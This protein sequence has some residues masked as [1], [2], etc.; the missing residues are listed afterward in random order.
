MENLKN[1]SRLARTLTKSVEQS[2]L[3]VGIMDLGCG[4]GPDNIFLELHNSGISVYYNGYDFND[5][6]VKRLLKNYPPNFN[7]H[8]KK[9]VT[10]RRVEMDENWFEEFSAG[11]ASTETDFSSY[12]EKQMIDNN[13]WGS[14]LVEKSKDEIYIHQI[15]EATRTSINLLKIDLDGPDFAYLQDYCSH[16]TQLPQFVS[17]EINYQGGGGINSNTFHNTDRYMK[18]LG[19]DLVAITSRTYSSKFLPSRFQY[20]IFAQTVKGIPFQGD[21]VYFRKTVYEKLDDVLRD[22]VLLDAFNLEDLAAKIVLENSSLIGMKEAKEIL[23]ILTSEVW[24]DTFESYEDLMKMWKENKTFFYPKVKEFQL[25]SHEDLSHLRIKEI[26]KVLVF[27]LYKK[28]KSKF[29]K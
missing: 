22:I 15:I 16:A 19:Y 27:R 10:K 17:L 11:Q 3:N 26:I 21:A 1:S 8:S 6:E 12:S 2:R 25:E 4:G 14:N 28:F 9:I 5:E 20:N 23:N 18:V 24:G 29:F 7:F 13:L